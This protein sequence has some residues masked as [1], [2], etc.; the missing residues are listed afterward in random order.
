MC[1]I[2]FAWQTHPEHSLVV[3]GNRDE[4]YQRPTSAARFWPETPQVLAGKDLQAGGTWLGITRSGRFAALTNIREPSMP[5][6]SQSRGHLVSHFLT[7]TLSAREYLDELKTEAKRYSGFNLLVCDGKELGW[8]NNRLGK[9][10]FLAPGIYGLSNAALDTP[11]PKVQKLKAGFTD[12]LL[13]PVNPESLLSLLADT[14]KAPDAELPHT[15]VGMT[16]ERMLSSAFIQSPSYGT[17]ASTVVLVGSE[18]AQL[19]EQGFDNGKK[20]ERVDIRFALER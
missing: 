13:A 11:W 20:A 6:G 18:R 5:Q 15:G 9:P 8:F 12:A 10:Q 14:Q 1:L 19:I 7:G 3:A 2:T 4:L 17:R 16:M